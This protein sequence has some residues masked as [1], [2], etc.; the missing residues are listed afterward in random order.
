MKSLLAVF[1]VMFAV[2]PSEAGH[3]VILQGKDRLVILDEAGQVA[4]EKRWGGIHDIHVLDNGH[5]MVQKM[6]S[7]VVEIDAKS[8]DVVWE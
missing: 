6:P 3:K 2:V 7:T 1:V 4:W 8:G 5:V